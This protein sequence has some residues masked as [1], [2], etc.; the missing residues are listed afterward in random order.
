MRIKRTDGVNTGNIVPID[1]KR[2]SRTADAASPLD[3]SSSAA[4]L[5]AIRQ[6]ASRGAHHLDIYRIAEIRQ[7]LD[8][9][10]CEIM[11]D[12]PDPMLEKLRNLVKNG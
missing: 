10:L 12:C 11:G 8:D 6:G 9:L 5:Q 1:S 4:V 3:P 2:S 7:A